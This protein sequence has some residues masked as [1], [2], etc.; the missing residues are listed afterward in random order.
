MNELLTHWGRVTHMWVSKLTI[1]GSDNGLAPGQRQA[2]F[3]ANAGILLIRTLATSAK[4]WAKFIHFRSSK[5][6]WSVIW[7]MAAIFVSASMS[8]KQSSCLWFETAWSS[9]HD[10]RTNGCSVCLKICIR[11]CC[12]MFCCTYII[13][14]SGCYWIIYLHSR[15]I[16]DNLHSNQNCL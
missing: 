4:S 1:I 10:T 15:Y 8:S 9:C 12:C 11:F 7:E 2:I 14:L 5:H 3:W 6:I 16:D 13:F